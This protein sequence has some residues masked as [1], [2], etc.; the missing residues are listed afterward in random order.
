MGQL[1]IVIV[2]IGLGYVVGSI[3]EKKHYR[4][5]ISREAQL[6]H[7]PTVSVKNMIEG[8]VDIIDARMVQ[9]S[10]VISIDHFKR[11]LASLRNIF[12]G[13][14]TAYESL[15]DRARREAILRMKEKS[16]NAD[17]VL[18]TRIET[19]TIGRS[20]NNRKSIGSIEAMAYGTA[21]SYRK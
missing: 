12:G 17:I 10:V 4:S 6:L 13:K 14:V 5:I 20:A 19:S 2:L 8:G 9:G 3:A 7:I 18:N 1:I 15:V 21:V 11:I 16:P